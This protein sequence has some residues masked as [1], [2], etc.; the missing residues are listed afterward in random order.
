MEDGFRIQSIA[1]E[2]FKG[3]TNRQEIDLKSR[4]AFI[5]GKNGNGKSSIVEAIRWG[6][7]GSPRGTNNVIANWDY[8]NQTRVEISMLRG[9]NLW[10][11]RRTVLR[12]VTGGN[13]V[14]L[15]D[16]QG[17]EHLLGEIM[18]QLDSVDSGEGMHIIFAPQSTPL[19]RQPDDLTTFE[20]TVIN[21]MGLTHPRSLLSQL[22]KFVDEQQ[23]MEVSIG[24]GIDEFQ[25]EVDKQLDY[26][27]RQRGLVLG[28][29]PWE[30]DR[31]PSVAESEIKVRVLKAE[32][33]ALEPNP[34]LAGVSL[35]ALIDSAEDSLNL[36]K[37]SDQESLKSELASV[38]EKQNR[39]SAFSEALQ[40]LND[41]ESQKQDSQS[42]LKECLGEMTLDALRD[43]VKTAREVA[44]SSTLQ[45]LLVD[46]ASSLLERDQSETAMCPVCQ[47]PHDRDT[48]LNALKESAENLAGISVEEQSRLETQLSEAESTVHEI[49]RLA[50]EMQTLN[51][52]S[53]DVK[54]S[55]EADDPGAMTDGVGI[56]EVK[57]KIRR[58]E[59]RQNSINEQ[60]ENQSGWIDTVQG[61]LSKLK[62]EGKFHKIQKEMV[63]LEQVGNQLNKVKGAYQ[64][65]VSF[66]T[67]VQSIQDAVASCLIEQL[68]AKIPAVSE[69]LSKAFSALTRHPYYDR[70]TISKT[71]LPKLELQ[72]ASSFDPSGLGHPSAVLNGQSE[73]ALA[74][75]PYFAL[76]QSEDS[77]TEVFLV[78]LDDP[79][80][81]FDEDHVDILVAE[82]AELGKHVQ[83]VV[84]SQESKKFRELV[85]RHFD[86]DS[87]QIIE[88][89]AWSHQSGPELIFE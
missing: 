61:Q 56:N 47:V 11:L 66:G 14:R 50:E 60:I 85:P 41:G 28:A 37:T 25:D 58:H 6:L 86:Q 68:E 21:H 29:P 24:A 57:L 26:L 33:T 53:N 45:S 44:D 77:P 38:A 55:I 8:P 19:R 62:E 70:L 69:K 16:A 20:R 39:L 31:V 89:A 59:E 49:E 72:V 74:L 13:D 71:T 43:K 32:I 64:D 87:Y 76:S 5:L 51:Q 67:S 40:A 4:H 18:P 75:V 2:G 35:D 17:K 42:R 82:L 30:G 23:V 22:E 78:L 84:A 54:E 46:Q 34:S 79:T 36:K 65:L 3:F 48:L 27:Q 73:S 9:S 83:L 12:G 7:F 88:P 1:I 81:A 15:T 10:N 80:R 52:K 63:D